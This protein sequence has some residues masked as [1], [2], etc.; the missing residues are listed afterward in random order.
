MNWLVEQNMQKG[1]SKEMM[2]KF[3]KVSR[4]QDRGRG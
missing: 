1:I 2:D 3:S 4:C